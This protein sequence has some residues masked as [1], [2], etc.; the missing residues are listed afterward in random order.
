GVFKIHDAGEYKQ[1]S[2]AMFQKSDLV[3]AQEFLPTPFD[4]RVGILDGQVLYVCKYF[5]AASHWQI[6]NW[7]TDKKDHEGDVQ[8]VA[9]DQAPSGLLKTALKAT[10]LIGKGLY[11]VDMK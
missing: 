7:N 10:A 4:W 6:V 11:G 1:V 2:A 5:M 3:I 8:C 9:V